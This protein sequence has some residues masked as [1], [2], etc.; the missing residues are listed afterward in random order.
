M[1]LTN[2]YFKLLNNKFMKVQVKFKVQMMK[3][4]QLRKVG[5]LLEIDSSTAILLAR[6]GNVEIVGYDIKREKKEIMVDTLIKQDMKGE[7]ENE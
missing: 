4:G 1:T 7:N 6:K 5:E 2:L 3:N